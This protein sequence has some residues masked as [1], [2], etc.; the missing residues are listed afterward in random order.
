MSS[1]SACSSGGPSS[2]TQDTSADDIIKKLK[3]LIDRSKSADTDSAQQH[4]GVAESP[5][6]RSGVESPKK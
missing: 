2:P 1:S 3:L 5:E 6:C 4:A